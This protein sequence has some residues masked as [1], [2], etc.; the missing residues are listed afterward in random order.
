MNFL[1]SSGLCRV[2]MF[3]ISGTNQP[4]QGRSLLAVSFAI[5][6]L[7][8]PRPAV[9]DQTL[10]L[11]DC[12]QLALKENRTIKNA[13]LERVSQ[14]YALRMAEDTFVPTLSLTTGP[15][16][17]GTAGNLGAASGAATGATTAT[18][19]SSS[20]TAIEK[21]PTG[22]VL[23]LSG[24]F[25][26]SQRNVTGK[27]WNITLEQPLLKNAGFDVNLETVRAAREQEQKNILALKATLTDT[28]T[29]IVTAYRSY[30]KAIQSLENNRQSLQRS[31]E[32]LATNRELIAAGRMAAIEII[33]SEADLARQEYD[34]L[35]AENS[36]DAT[37][38]ALTKA[39][40]VDKNRR[41][42][43]VQETTIPPLPYTL[44]QAL[45]LAFENRPDYQQLLLDYAR[46]KRAVTI[47][48]RNTLWD[49]SLTGN[50]S[51][52]YL[53]SNG[54]WYTGMQLTI[55]LDNLYRS[56]ADRQAALVADISRKKFENDLGKRRE[57]IEIEIQDALRSAEMSHRQIKLATLSRTLSEKKVEVETEKLKA[58]RSTNFQLVSFQN[59][60]KQA[61]QRELDAITDYLNALTS[62]DRTLGITLDRLGIA[63]VDRN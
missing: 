42:R 43:P 30:A 57:E 16:L 12:I 29:S 6:L 40:D 62:L 26:T 54:S 32:L 36:L 18:T 28:L 9:A 41:I 47:A 10:S 52:D 53:S 17:S 38:L 19:T 46:T 8:V 55:P 31:K 5:L 22:A 7:A 11:T 35:A 34:L 14:K 49:L 3:Q 4:V 45:Q 50:Y 21:I 13:Y 51:N 56:S 20:L 2:Q 39:I 61:Q 60:L 44:E 58:G 24:S 15:K 63:L 1:A 59:D 27:G 37:R 23:T 48:K 25:D 33:Q